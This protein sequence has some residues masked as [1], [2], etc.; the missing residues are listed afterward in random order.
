MVVLQCLIEESN[1]VLINEMLASGAGE[2][3]KSKYSYNELEKEL[4]N[5][6][7]YIYEH[8]NDEEKTKEY[9]ENYNKDKMIAL[10]CVGYCLVV[11]K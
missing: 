5:M 4:L 9:F 10:K 6:G 11:K 8:L 1:N 7:L 3:I 2:K